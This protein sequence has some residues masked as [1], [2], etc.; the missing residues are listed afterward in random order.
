MYDVVVIGAGPAGLSAGL[1]ASRAKLSTL[2]IEKMYPG[3]QAAN[4]YII[5][6]YP[7][8]AEGITGSELAD[9]LKVQ[10]E[11]FG[12]ELINGDV[13]ELKKLDDR[14]LINMKRDSL[15]ARSVIL[16]MG[17][18]PR[19]LGVKGENEFV[20]RGVSYCATCDGAF[21]MNKPIIMVGGGDTAIEEALFL[22]RFASQITVIHRRNELRA[23]KILQ[24]RAFSNEKINF[25]WDSV[26]EEIKG[27][28]ALEEVV[29]KNVKTG[30]LKSVYGAGIF[31]AIG[32]TPNN[33][34]VKDLVELDD[35]G[36]VIT[37]DRMNTSLLG[38]FAAGDL[39]QKALRQVVTAVSDGAIAAVEAGKYLES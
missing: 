18:E 35:N 22:T 31:V 19:K 10:A 26:V 17:A 34:L 20:G 24:D 39:R 6:N 14:F 23:T 8:F 38:V 4:T 7:G 21:Y 29:V 11:K 30:E 32:Y 36:Y 28:D 12:A 33:D 3:G 13:K 9:R 27:K 25:V 15:E 1:Y 2:L 5:E 16:A 37:D